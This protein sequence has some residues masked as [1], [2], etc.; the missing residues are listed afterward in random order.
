[1][2]CGDV[3][4]VVRDDYG[5]VTKASAGNVR[6]LPTLVSSG[7]DTGK[8]EQNPRE[9]LSEPQEDFHRLCPDGARPKRNRSRWRI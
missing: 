8:A 1:M 6:N 3:H 4:L 2:E 7:G 5:G 9:G